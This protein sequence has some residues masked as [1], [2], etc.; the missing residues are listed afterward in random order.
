MN[1]NILLKKTSVYKTKHGP[2]L[3]TQII[4]HSSPLILSNAKQK[5]ERSFRTPTL[6]HQSSQKQ[7][8]APFPSVNE[9][10]AYPLEYTSKSTLHSHLQ[11]PSNT[12]RPNHN[13]NCIPPPTSREHS[14]VFTVTNCHNHFHNRAWLNQPIYLT[15]NPSC[16]IWVHTVFQFTR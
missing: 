4:C 1:T 13:H 3:P 5:R 14:L 6:H 7:T 16:L 9:I 8:L 12:T 15:L 10:D 2:I 11:P